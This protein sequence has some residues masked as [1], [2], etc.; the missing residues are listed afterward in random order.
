MNVCEIHCNHPVSSSRAHVITFTLH[1]M[2]LAQISLAVLSS[3]VKLMQRA[4]PWA[5]LSP[6]GLKG[7]GA[8]R[9]G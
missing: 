1:S 8:S 2:R 4:T 9:H 3:G 6:N 7:K 5:M